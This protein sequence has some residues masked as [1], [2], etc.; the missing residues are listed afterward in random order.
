MKDQ[1]KAIRTQSERTSN[2]EHS[3]PLYMTSSFVFENAEQARRLFAGEEEGYIY[4]RYDN[5]NT[6]ELV[7]KLVDLEKTED[8]VPM[9]SGMA[10]V[11][12]SFAALLGSGDHIV[13]C[14]S[15]FGSTHQILTQLFPKWGIT[16][17]YV[18]VDADE[19]AW[20]AAV[21][22][23]TKMMFLETPTNPA[24]DIVDLEWAG[25]FA[26][27]HGVI[28]NVDN[29]FAT[30]YLQNPAVYGAGLITH[31]TT[32]FMDGQGR[33][34]GGIVLGKKDLIEKIRFFARHTGPA[35]SPFNAWL[36]SK[37]LE[38]LGL[39]M[40]RHCDNAEKLASEL[41]KMRGIRS[42]RYP[43]LPSHPRYEIAKKQMR[44][45]GGLVSFEL[46][47]GIDRGRKF[48][49][50]LEM[51]SLTSNLGDARTIATHPASTT[52]SKLTDEERAD[53]GITPGL[54]RIS[55]GYES[56]EDIIGDIS[57]ALER[58]G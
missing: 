40:D 52:H 16:H 36:V 6:T 29:C 23:E 20:E 10:A 53:V 3:V 4:S 15:I 11:F 21:T 39:R 14:R 44:R 27:K 37:S 24:L 5:P 25:H 8:G 41:E 30:P 46:D 50:S 19:N 2:R 9:A 48:L 49:D 35:L 7:N 47:G 58:S 13:S 42:V 32:K 55:V 22:P 56:Y 51:I 57:R 45:G 34:I 33:T 43:H 12:A 1:T 17:T 54:V 26:E 28:L 38:T 18:D 31:S